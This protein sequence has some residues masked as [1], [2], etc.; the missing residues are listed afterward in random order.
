VIAWW[1]S[2]ATTTTLPAAFSPITTVLSSPNTFAL[3]VVSFAFPTFGL[4][5]SESSNPLNSLELE[6]KQQQAVVGS[7]GVQLKNKVWLNREGRS[8]VA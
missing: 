2:A 7:G 1:H 4:G 8:D 5:A 6:T 3:V